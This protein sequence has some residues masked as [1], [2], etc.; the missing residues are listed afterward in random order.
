MQGILLS[1]FKK[2]VQV[3]G[4]TLKERS[5]SLSCFLFCRFFSNRCVNECTIENTELVAV[6]KM[7]FLRE[8]ESVLFGVIKCFVTFYDTKQRSSGCMFIKPELELDI[9]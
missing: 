3:Y 2:L 8:N 5:I 4:G 1:A 6:N 9:H 7:A